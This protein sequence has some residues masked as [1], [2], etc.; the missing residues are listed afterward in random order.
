MTWFGAFFWSFHLFIINTK[1]HMQGA[2]FFGQQWPFPVTGGKSKP[3]L[4]AWIVAGLHCWKNTEHQECLAL[5]AELACN[6]YDFL[7]IILVSWLTKTQEFFQ[8]IL[9]FTV[10]RI[11]HFKGTARNPTTRRIQ[12]YLTFWK[13]LS[14][15]YLVALLRLGCRNKMINGR[16]IP[17]TST[18]L[19]Q[20][21]YNNAFI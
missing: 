15:T 9:P 21:L 20:S 8:S 4:L 5:G 19:L 7:F 17:Q 1:K 11:S 16:L 6:V 18:A 13:S 3:C 12:D 10:A 14:K 2:K